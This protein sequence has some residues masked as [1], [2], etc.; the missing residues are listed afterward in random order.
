MRKN[1]RVFVSGASGNLGSAIVQRLETRPEIEVVILKRDSENSYV[2]NLLIHDKEPFTGRNTFIHCGWDVSNRKATA[3]I[4]SANETKALASTC[5]LLNI[6]M[7]FLSSASASEQSRSNYGKAK[8]LAENHVIGSGGIVLRPGL[9]LFNPPK[10]LQKRVVSFRRIP[11]KVKFVPDICIETIE[12]ESFLYEIEKHIG[13]FESS[14]K[15]IDI[16]DGLVGLNQLIAQSS[17][18]HGIVV[19][20]PIGILEKL[21]EFIGRYNNQIFAFYDSFTSIYKIEK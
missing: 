10:G 18:K 13:N 4:K 7:L 3:Q 16:S 6:E 12:V 1:Q 21:L 15:M 14:G 20:I 17:K 19:Y 11:V 2:G 9:V 8:Y 5:E